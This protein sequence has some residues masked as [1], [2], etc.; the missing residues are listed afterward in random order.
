MIVR[1][2]NLRFLKAGSVGN[3]LSTLGVDGA[4]GIGFDG[5]DPHPGRSTS[6]VGTIFF[7]QTKESVF[8][9]SP[10]MRKKNEV[11]FTLEHNLR[12]L[13]K[14]KFVRSSGVAF[15]PLQPT[16]STF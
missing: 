3:G 13:A 5:C 11:F 9:A 6:V 14:P 2:K 8:R 10:E 15:T 4:C 7:P 1:Y 16:T 12:G